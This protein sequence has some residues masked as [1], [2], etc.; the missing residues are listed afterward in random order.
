MGLGCSS[1]VVCSRC[2][3]CKK[4]INAGAELLTWLAMHAAWSAEHVCRSVQS[5]RWIT[6]E[7]RIDLRKG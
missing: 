6:R 1:V 2:C 4:G 7:R 5:C 3:Y